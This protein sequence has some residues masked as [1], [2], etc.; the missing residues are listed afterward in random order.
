[1]LGVGELAVKLVYREGQKADLA[2]ACEKA[3]INIPS[4]LLTSSPSLKKS[5]M[6]NRL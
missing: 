2:R 6:I 4:I 1:M 5:A 3:Y